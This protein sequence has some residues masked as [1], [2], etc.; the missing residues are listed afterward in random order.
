MSRLH[1]SKVTE[2]GGQ[3]QMNLDGLSA[4]GVIP[5]CEKTGTNVDLHLVAY[6][7]PD[8]ADFTASILGADYRH[9]VRSNTTLSVPIS[10]LSLGAIQSLETRKKIPIGTVAAENLRAW[11]KL[12]ADA[13]W[14]EV[15]EASQ[16]RQVALELDDAAGLGL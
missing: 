1:E 3:T 14:E 11:L 9:L 15:A 8:T 6:D 5:R 4:M 16:V 2:I 10:I 12:G 13:S 7:D